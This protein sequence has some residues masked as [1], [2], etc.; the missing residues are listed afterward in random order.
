[1]SDSEHAAALCKAFRGLAHKCYWMH[2]R[3]NRTRNTEDTPSEDEVKAR[4]DLLI[5]FEKSSLP[6]FRQQL[7]D[8]LESLDLKAQGTDPNPKL[9]EA[10]EI[11]SKLE[12][13]LNQISSSVNDLYLAISAM[14]KKSIKIDQDHGVLKKIRLDSLLSKMTNLLTE[15]FSPLFTQYSEFISSGQFAHN[16]ADFSEDQAEVTSN[17]DQIIERTAKIIEALDG[18]IVWLP[19]PDFG[20]LQDY[21][22]FLPGQLSDNLSKFTERINA[23]KSLDGEPSDGFHTRARAVQL[24]QHAIPLL[25]FGRIFFQKLLNKPPFTFGDHL[26]SFDLERFVW[27]A[28]PIGWDIITI[29]DHLS[30]IYQGEDVKSNIDAVERFCDRVKGRFYYSLDFISSFLVPLDSALS[31]EEV[32]N[33]TFSTIRS[34]F[35]KAIDSFLVSVRQFKVDMPAAA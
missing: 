30:D 1:M 23:A 34:E 5:E 26:C 2:G 25:K 13:T 24:M 10:L 19:R 28:A 22:D 12:L 7:S 15:E 6:S 20:F 35:P 29:L 16:E 18:A 3:P 33:D 8:L 27:Q 4:K 32:F 21:W 9:T 17:R 14:G 31:S 11:V